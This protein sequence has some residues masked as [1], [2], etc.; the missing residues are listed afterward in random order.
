MLKGLMLKCDKLIV[1]G[2]PTCADLFA[3]GNADGLDEGGAPPSTWVYTHGGGPSA[4]A[5]AASDDGFF[6]VDTSKKRSG[7]G[8]WGPS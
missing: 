6:D 3:G 8:S 1:A 2:P 4:N 5:I 7:D